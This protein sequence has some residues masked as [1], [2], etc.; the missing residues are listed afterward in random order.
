MPRPSVPYVAD[1]STGRSK[2]R[3][4]VEA[5][6]SRLRSGDENGPGILD[7]ILATTR[8]PSEPLYVH[9]S[10]DPRKTYL[11]RASRIASSRNAD[12][13]LWCVFADISRACTHLPPHSRNVLATKYVNEW[14]NDSTAN[15]F[16]V[17]YSEIDRIVTESMDRIAAILDR[18]PCTP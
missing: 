11:G 4:Y 13:H 18:K 12:E 3:E 10:R 1:P 7:S 17:H 2:T 15:F 16:G 9:K 14:S 8:K 6:F 5:F